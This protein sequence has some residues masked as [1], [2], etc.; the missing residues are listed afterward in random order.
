VAARLEAFKQKAA[1]PAK[2][3]Q[4]SSVW[5]DFSRFCKASGVA[6]SP[7]ARR[8]AEYVMLMTEHGHRLP[9]IT[10]AVSH[11]EDCAAERGLPALRSDPLIKQVLKA[12]ARE[13]QGDAGSPRKILDRREADAALMY[14]SSA[15]REAVEASRRMLRAAQRGG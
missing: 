4:R 7:T 9:A 2:L 14:A 11:L 13:A 10:R 8:V 3:E 15:G 5:R 1:A 12:A 6:A